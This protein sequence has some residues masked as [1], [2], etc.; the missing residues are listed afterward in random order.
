MVRNRRD[1]LKEADRRSQG[2][3][4]I[5][6]GGGAAGMS[7]ALALAR[8]GVRCTVVEE[9]A[10][11][12]GLPADLACMGRRTCSDCGV[13]TVHDHVASAEADANIRILT[14]SRLDVLERHGETYRATVV[15]S[16]HLVDNDRCDGCG[17]CISACPKGAISIAKGPLAVIDPEKCN[18]QEGC[19]LCADACRKEAIDLVLDEES[20]AV[21][22]DSVIVAIGAQPFDPALDPRLGYGFV[23]GV[24]TAKDLEMRLKQGQWPEGKLPSKVAFIQCVGSR[25]SKEGTQ[26]CS[27]ACCKYAFKLATLIREIAPAAEQTFFFMDWR[28]CDSADDLLAWAKRQKLVKAVRSRP[29][30]IVQGDAGPMVRYAKEGDGQVVEEM[31]DLV[32]LSVGMVP[33]RDAAMTASM[34]GAK[35]NP[36][37]FFFSEGRPA[38]GL[39]QKGIFFAGACA[40]PKE[41]EET[42]IEAGVA[43]AKAAAYLGARK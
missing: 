17:E 32:I 4:A 22:A 26:L 20:E 28:P 13:C 10:C 1:E 25:T 19:H 42:L 6:L 34:F 30:E 3:R 38:A 21:E 41:I 8:R 24:L 9:A 40:G 35:L 2:G 11:V 23:N 39:E 43:A 15:T 18:R 5:I 31:F 27:K 29:A 14:S 16:P 7:S 36:Q 37:G 33:A 12:G